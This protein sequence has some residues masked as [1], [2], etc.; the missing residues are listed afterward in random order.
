MQNQVVFKSNQGRDLILAQ[1]DRLL[2]QWPVP[3]EAFE[4]STR[5]ARTFV[6][7]SGSKSA[8]P[9]LLLHGSTSNAPMWI[10][11]VTELSRTHRVYALDIPG[12]PGKSEAVRPALNGPV[13]AQWLEAVCS[14]LE[15]NTLSLVGISL[16]GFLALK[17]ATTYP[18]RLEKLVLLCPAG[19]A[20]QKASFLPRA[21]LF[22]LLGDW[23]R[24]RILRYVY[25]DT[26]MPPEA[27]AY[28]K[29]IAANFA[30]RM[31][32]IPLFSDAELQRITAP[33]LLIAGARDVLLDTPKTVARLAVL[34][35]DFEAQVLPDVGH[36]VIGVTDRIVAFLR[37]EDFR[38]APVV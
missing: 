34:L 29:L 27:V 31:E 14:A 8:P 35:P 6:I 2:E 9:V 33:T 30:P 22:S 28:S 36:A 1:Y 38:L 12:E 13:Y 19:V 32:T 5:H 37:Q 15:I 16:G 17:F 18:D 11:D 21:F 10:G 25:G 24:D 23:G 3:F 26:P 20:P 7:A 4:L